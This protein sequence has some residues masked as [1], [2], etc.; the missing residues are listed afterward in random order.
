MKL[1]AKLGRTAAKVERISLHPR[2]S[3]LEHFG[4]DAVLRDT[5]AEFTERTG[6][7]G[8]LTGDALKARLPADTELALHRL[9]QEA[10]ENVEKHAHARHVTVA[11]TESGAFVQLAINDDSIG[12]DAEHHAARRK[13]WGSWGCSGR[14]NE[15]PAW[16]GASLSSPVRESARKS[17][18][19]FRCWRQSLPI[20]KT[21]KMSNKAKPP[22]AHKRRHVMGGDADLQK[23]LGV[24][25]RACRHELKISQEELGWRADVHRTYITDIERGARNVT[26]RTVANL[27]TAL[28]VTIGRLFAH[29]TAPAGAPARDVAETAVGELREVLLVEYNVVAATATARA[30]KRAKL[31]N[32]LRIVRDGE[33]ALDYLF[34]TGR[35]AKRKP[36]RPQLILLVHDLPRMSGPEFMRRVKG[37]KRTRDI[38]IVLLT[39]SHR[40]R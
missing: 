32:P 31:T 6:V 18:C 12:L 22:H 8:N 23:R 27:A 40:R 10:L 4:P 38:P 26:L 36:D 37:D 19:A 2:P 28:Q 17:K 15:P 16:A 13:A 30:F 35:Y 1:R 11:L 3:A 34:G 24:V 5:T 39:V 7:A 21:L 33:C 14:A 29:V 9:L 20:G 25:V